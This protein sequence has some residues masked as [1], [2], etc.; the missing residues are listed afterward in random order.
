[1]GFLRD[2]FS[3]I[4]DQAHTQ[5]AGLD[6]L[7][8][9]DFHGFEDRAVEQTTRDVMENDALR[10]VGLPIADF[11]SFGLT[12]PA[13]K[14]KYNKMM[15]GE[16]GFQW[17]DLAKSVAGNY[18]A[19][20]FLPGTKTDSLG[21]LGYNVAAGAGRGAIS[22]GIQ[23]NSMTEGAKGGAIS[24][25]IMSGG[26]YLGNMFRPEAS[27]Y[28]PTNQGQGLYNEITQTS[29]APQGDR[30]D[31]FRADG[32][33]APQ[34]SKVS[35]V[36][37][38]SPLAYNSTQTTAPEATSLT[39]NLGQRF[40]DFISGLMPN[41][42]VRGGDVAQGLAGLY[43]GYRR[44]KAG[45]E[46]SEAMGANRGSYETQLRQNLARRDAA[47]GRR[48]N[49]GGREVELQAA[50]AQ[51]DSRNAPARMAANEMRYSGLD[52]I[53]RSG[54]QMGGNLGWFGPQYQRQD[55]ALRPLGTV[56]PL[57]LMPEIP[58][59]TGLSLNEMSATPRM[60][61]RF[62]ADGPHLGGWEY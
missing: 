62:S 58:L 13:V 34:Q 9:F 5:A 15:T 12:S 37:A 57:P 48:S 55:P 3:G 27:S 42:A 2:L 36:D 45:K 18:V 52:N 29:S 11:F 35:Y 4:D 41:S 8:R 31:Y 49:Y 24:G 43:S 38:S 1:M 21:S 59:H 16:S 51:L 23:G 47:S 25:G 44:R 19:N 32:A 17:E 20:Q 28:V 33:T 26:D 30:A 60:P 14:A 39:G 46:L 61:R 56:Q 6:D 54:L 7:H 53:L 50:L 22:S 10:T 40:T